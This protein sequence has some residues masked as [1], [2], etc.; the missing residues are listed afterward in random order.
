M[1]GVQ[2]YIRLYDNKNYTESIWSVNCKTDKYL[3]AYFVAVSDLKP[4][5]MD[6]VERNEN[7]WTF[8]AIS[9]QLLSVSYLNELYFNNLNSFCKTISIV[10]IKCWVSYRGLWL[11]ILDIRSIIF[12]RL[13]RKYC[14]CCCLFCSKNKENRIVQCENF[15][16]CWY[17]STQSFISLI[18]QFIVSLLII[19]LLL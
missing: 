5:N 12:N 10:Y 11:C 14:C 4:M 6:K 9:A 15:C 1:F 7:I 17:K 13:W 8:P 3:N 16:N 18:S 2:I 19:Y